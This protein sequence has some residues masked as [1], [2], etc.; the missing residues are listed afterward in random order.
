MAQR[1]VF[2]GP[3][4]LHRKLDD[5]CHIFADKGESEV[6]YVTQVSQ[7]HALKLHWELEEEAA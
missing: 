2:L 7:D 3:W 6:V 5:R 4:L 1:A